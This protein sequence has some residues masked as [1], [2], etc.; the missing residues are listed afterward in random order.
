MEYAR[1]GSSGLEVSRLALGCM[2]FGDPT[3]G[4]DSWTLSQDRAAQVVEAAVESGVNFFD[5]ANVYSAGSSEEILGVILPKFIRRDEAVIAT[6]VNGPMRE[7]RNAEGLSRKAILTEVEASLRR[8]RTDHVDVLYI[9]RWDPNTPIAETLDTLDLLVTQ[10]KVRYLGASSMAAWQFS[11]LLY[12]ADL[13]R[14]RR[15]VVM[16]NHYNLLSREEEREM[17]P[18]CR[19]QGIA[20]VPWSPLARGRLARGRRSQSTARAADDAYGDSLYGFN[21]E[22][23]DRIIDRLGALSVTRGLPMATLAL[24]WVLHQSPVV[25]PVVGV[26]SADQWTGAAR[27]LEVQFSSAELQGLQEPYR[28]GLPVGYA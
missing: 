4:A 23:E 26:T 28:P 20:V 24:A 13:L 16:Q 11:A 25:A 1:L 2:S 9:H 3:R 19:D 10:G 17:L 15:M 22:A 14:L 7:G 6:K 21:P 12:T 27:A 8:L 5:T 18:L